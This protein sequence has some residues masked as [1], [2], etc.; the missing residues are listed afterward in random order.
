M[1]E[2]SI[3]SAFFHTFAQWPADLCVCM[4][5]YPQGL[6]ENVL[7]LVHP[8]MILLYSFCRSLVGVCNSC[9][10]HFSMPPFQKRLIKGYPQEDLSYIYHP[11]STTCRM[12]LVHLHRPHSQVFLPCLVDGWAAVWVQYWA[13]HVGYPCCL[14]GSWEILPSGS[15]TEV[16]NSKLKVVNMLVEQLTDLGLLQVDH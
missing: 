3:D 10:G 8:V 14:T 13:M 5:F 4:G 9:A 2:P 15:H 7:W 12:T 11:R 6:V 1:L 16:W